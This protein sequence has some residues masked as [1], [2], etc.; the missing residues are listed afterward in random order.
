[1]SYLKG[2]QIY[3][4]ALKHQRNTTWKLWLYRVR[5]PLVQL[6]YRVCETLTEDDTHNVLNI[7]ST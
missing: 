7:P 5:L 1:M 6:I 4:Q 3:W 2:D